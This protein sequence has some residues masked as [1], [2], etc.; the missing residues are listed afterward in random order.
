MR[1]GL[2]RREKKDLTLPL[3]SEANLVINLQFKA[4]FSLDKLTF[5]RFSGEAHQIRGNRSDELKT[6][7]NVNNGELTQLDFCVTQPLTSELFNVHVAINSFS[8]VLTKYK[9]SKGNVYISIS[10]EIIVFAVIALQ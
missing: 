10:V 3:R 9:S 2:K 7:K 5:Q 8:A 4:F 1:Y 6:E